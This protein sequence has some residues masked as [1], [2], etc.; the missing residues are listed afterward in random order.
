MI[1]AEL[2]SELNKSAN[3]DIP[4]SLRAYSTKQQGLFKHS[5]MQRLINLQFPFQERGSIAA[6]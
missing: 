5:L 4:A 6:D 1:K 3:L 2:T